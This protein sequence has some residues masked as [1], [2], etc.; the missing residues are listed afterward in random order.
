MVGFQVYM[1]VDE[2]VYPIRESYLKVIREM[3][4]WL[5]PDFEEVY[6]R[7]DYFYLDR[8]TNAG[9]PGLDRQYPMPDFNEALRRLGDSKLFFA[10]PFEGSRDF[11][12]A[13]Y[14][15][16]GIVQFITTRGRDNNKDFYFNNAYKKTIDWLIQYGL[17]FSELVLTND[18]LAHIRRLEKELEV[19]FLVG[20]DDNLDSLVSIVGNSSSMK[21]ILLDRS[22]NKLNSNLA[23]I[24]FE[25]MG[26][27]IRVRDLVEARQKLIE[28]VGQ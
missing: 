24:E 7:S 5:P 3:A 21:G 6:L 18:K 4:P 8:F 10:P 2:T 9:M 28:V 27:V 12:E 13:V 25:R 14:G 22:Y 23:A 15:L 16:G 17:R 11:C 1:D 19:P 20:V 26:R